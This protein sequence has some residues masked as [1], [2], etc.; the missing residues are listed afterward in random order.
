MAI[1]YD[2]MDYPS[3]NKTILYFHSKSSINLFIFS[4]VHHECVSGHGHGD[5]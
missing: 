4:Q 3:I 2:T 1:R 5:W